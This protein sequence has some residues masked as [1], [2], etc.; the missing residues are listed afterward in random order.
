MDETTHNMHRTPEEADRTRKQFFNDSAGSWMDSWYKDE[1]TG[2]YDKHRKD[3]DRLFGLVPLK[4]GD[5][6]LDAGCGTGV[7]VPEILPRITESGLLYELDF[8]EKM[9]EENRKLH[10]AANLRFVVA[11]AAHPPRKLLPDGSCDAVFCF[12]CFPH[13]HDKEGALQAMARVL[14]PGGTLAVAHFISSQ[15]VRH[16]HAGCHAVMHDHL[17]D[18]GAMR[19]MFARASLGIATFIDEAGFYCVLGTKT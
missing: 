9:I 12:S 8:A 14:K 19:A 2:H 13:F 3:F 10:P 6:V 16:H 7:L 1:A 15:E 11:D 17:P 18:E 5:R 4:A